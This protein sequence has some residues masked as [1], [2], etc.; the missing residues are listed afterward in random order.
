[1][2]TNVIVVLSLG[3]LALRYGS[4]K[5]PSRRSDDMSDFGEEEATA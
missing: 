1:M 5:F 2:H 3:V 4:H